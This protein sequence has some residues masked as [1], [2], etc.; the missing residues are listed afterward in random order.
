MPHIQC[1]STWLRVV[2]GKLRK[3]STQTHTLLLQHSNP[4]SNLKILTPTTQRKEKK[5]SFMKCKSLEP[6]ENEIGL[7]G[8][9]GSMPNWEYGE[10]IERGR[11]WRS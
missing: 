3:K 1:N 7:E 10:R 11:R 2:R 4:L 8:M 9:E 5:W 6:L